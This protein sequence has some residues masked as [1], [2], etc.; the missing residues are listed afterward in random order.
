MKRPMDEELEV[1]IIAVIFPNECRRAFACAGNV[2][3]LKVWPMG[4]AKWLS[5]DL[6]FWLSPTRFT[7]N[8]PDVHGV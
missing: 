4:G 2:F 6:P 5:K 8:W 1:L 7:F 3:M